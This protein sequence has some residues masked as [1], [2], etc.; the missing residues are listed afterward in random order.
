MRLR[1]ITEWLDDSGYIFKLQGNGGV[2]I[3]G[4]SSLENCKGD[5]I[6][7]V[8]KAA[9]Y[10]EA[11]NKE[12]VV[13]AVV[14]KGVIIDVPHQIISENSKEVFFAIL[15]HFWGRDNR[16]GQIG[17]GTFISPDAEIDPTVTIGYN[18]SI[19]GR[20]KIDAYTVIENN[21]TIMND[22]AIGSSCIIHSGAVIGKDG[23]GYAFD[24]DNNPVKVPHFGGVK[25]GNRVEIGANTTIDRGTLD[26][27]V[28][29]DDVKID[30]LVHIA[31]NVE[32]GKGTLIVGCV[33]VGGSCRIGEKSYIAPNAIIR[34]QRT[35]GNNSFIGMGVVMNEPIGDNVVW[36][37]NGQKPKNNRDYRRFL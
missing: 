22:V 20:I 2:L 23:F 32:I 31:H 8:K 21:V 36:A 34:N 11:E 24:S 9:N 1:D 16:A 7:W 37:T 17:Q 6:T 15:Q 14:Q 4:F 12:E 33:S 5:R 28:I 13:C 18:C 30:N 10:E 27:T 3:N 19:V 35:V 25:I 29:S 26:S